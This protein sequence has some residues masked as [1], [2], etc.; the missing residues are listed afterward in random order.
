VSQLSSAATVDVA[1]LVRPALRTAPTYVPA[2]SEHHHDEHRERQIKLDMNE[3]PYGPSPMT[4]AALSQFVLTNRYPSFTQE[5]LRA[6]L[7]DY[8]GVPVS[9]VFVGAGLDDVLLNLFTVL[10]DPGD[11]VIISEPTFGVYRALVGVRGGTTVD[12]PLTPRPDWN[13]D[14]PAI[15]AAV[16]PR[17]KLIIVC[18]P[19]NPTGNLFSHEAVEELVAGAPCLVAIDEAYA[20]FAGTTV[21]PLMDR[22]SHVCILRTMSKWAGLAGMRVGYGAFP[23]ALMPAIWSVAPSFCNIS[24]A[25]EVA[26]IAS[27]QDRDYLVAVVQRIIAD[28]DALADR[29]RQIPGVEPFP[30]AT[31]FLLVK[32]PVENAKPIV[33]GLAARGIHVRYFGDPGHNML[34]CLRVSI[35]TAEENMLFADELEELLEEAPR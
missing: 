3:S 5:P 4:R 10:I 9:R 21:L 8:L 12:V 28:R 23:D 11:E 19:N 24:T 35:G 2:R 15:L 7:A 32:L 17:T 6:A 26:A 33:D 13:L 1:A 25:A 34:D 14:V 22:Y 16:T 31:N 30:S 27:I 20:E 18:N 29:L